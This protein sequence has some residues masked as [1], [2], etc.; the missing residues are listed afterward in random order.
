MKR[1]LIALASCALLIIAAGYSGAGSTET[2]VPA[3]LKVY[4]AD[5]ENE[6]RFE[7]K[8]FSPTEGGV[9][10]TVAARETPFEISIESDEFVALFR[11]LDDGTNIRVVAEVPNGGGSTWAESVG[12]V[13][14]ILRDGAKLT[15]SGL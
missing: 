8:Y 15:S 9:N 12:N 1:S 2:P 3:V 10:E 13:A 6:V 11:S 4:S 5:A 7:G 14:L